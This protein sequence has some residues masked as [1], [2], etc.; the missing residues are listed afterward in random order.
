MACQ[1]H[2]YGI[3]DDTVLAA[4]LLHDVVEDTDASLA[5]LP[6]S[7]EV[8]EIVGLLS[9]EVPDE[10]D[11]DSAKKLYYE[12]IRTNQKACLI[13]LLD[14]CNNVS[15]MA[16]SFT[17]TRLKEYI[18]ETENYVL[19]LASVLKNESIE[20]NEVAFLLKYHII[21]VIET[22]KNLIC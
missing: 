6:A 1:A 22:I 18:V 4:I 21:S 9:F 2:A 20:Y 11:W 16:A 17:K 13:K 3:K 15:T 5:D 8:K 12:R 14:R 7:D 19:P 10:M